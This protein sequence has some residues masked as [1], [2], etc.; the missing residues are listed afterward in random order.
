MKEKTLRNTFSLCPVCL[1]RLPARHVQVGDDVYLKKTCDIHGSFSTLIW[2][3]NQS[4]PMDQWRG[5]ADEIPADQCPPCPEDCGLCGAHTQA[6]CCV[7]LDLTQK[8]NLNCAFCFAGT[9]SSSQE[10]PSL[11][12]VRHWLRSLADMG[13]TFVHLSGGEPTLREDLPEIVRYAKDCGFEYIQLNPNGLKLAESE[14]YVQTLA[15]AGVSFVFLQFDGTE[16]DIYQKLRGRPLLKQKLK[17]A[18]NCGKHNLGV[19]LVCTVVPHVNTRN[20]GELLRLAASL[21]PAVRGVHFQPVSYFGRYPAPPTDDA[22]FTLPDLIREIENQT[23]GQIPASALL[24]SQCDHP[25]CGLHGDF[26]V[27]PDGF[28]ALT[29]KGAAGSNAASCCA[30]AVSAAGYRASDATESAG[31]GS[32][33]SCAPTVSVAADCCVPGSAES[34]GSGS[35]SCCAPDGA[36]SAGCRAP[37]VAVA[38]DSSSCCCAPFSSASMLAAERSRNFIGRRWKRQESSAL[39][40]STNGSTADASVD[41]TSFNGFLERVRTHG[42]TITAMAF[43]DCYNLDLERLRHCSL[44]TYDG[45]NLAPLCVRYLTPRQS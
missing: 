29:G 25:M 3:G 9:G 38:V 17:A 20:I 42:F 28:Y 23:G 34:A 11:D 16:E 40:S 18:E 45:K 39:D 37:A 31:S 14:T 43:Q 6:T 21:S 35:V 36:D 24:P 2:R 13:K 19:A 15:A 26:I 8:C 1:K 41:I 44:H 22:R 12:T 7:V 5:P 33:S 30:P 27:M 32:V 10:D 4:V